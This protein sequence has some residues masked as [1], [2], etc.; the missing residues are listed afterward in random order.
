MK[1]RKEKRNVTREE[2]NRAM[3]EEEQDVKF[4][5]D[6]KEYSRTID[7][8]DLIDI[9]DKEYWVLDILNMILDSYGRI[10]EFR[11]ENGSKLYMA[12]EATTQMN[13]TICDVLVNNGIHTIWREYEYLHYRY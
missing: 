12:Y 13:L 6:W 11:M 9:E 7:L 8:D 10:I 2:I 4:E 3:E 1:Q 5:W